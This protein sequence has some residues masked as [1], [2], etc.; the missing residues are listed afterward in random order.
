VGASGISPISLE[1]RINKVIS[2]NQAIV[3]TLGN[4]FI[5]LN[6][7]REVGKARHL[8]RILPTVFYRPDV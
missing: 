5:D 4:G 6:I 2:Q 7:F 3:E 1:Q 8:S